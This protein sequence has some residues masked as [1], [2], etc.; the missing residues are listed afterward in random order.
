MISL[1]SEYNLACF[2]SI[3]CFITITLLL[4]A[5]FMFGIELGV[6]FAVRYSSDPLVKR[7][8]FG[9]VGVPD[10]NIIF[11]LRRTV[12]AFTG[13]SQE[14]QIKLSQASSLTPRELITDGRFELN[15]RT[16]LRKLDFLFGDSVDEDAE[17]MYATNGFIGSESVASFFRTWRG[18]SFCH[19][20]NQCLSI[21]QWSGN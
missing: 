16:L 10:P 15:A 9:H 2:Q 5:N 6:I 17:V 3:T 1:F 4:N 12:L 14:R 8:Y 13:K 21:D 11:N 20:F 18:C 7:R 19:P